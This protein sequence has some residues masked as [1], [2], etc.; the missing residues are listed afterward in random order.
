MPLAGPKQQRGSVG[1]PLL[2]STGAYPEAAGL[3]VPRCRRS[4]CHRWSA[5]ALHRTGH[6]Q[7]L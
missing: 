6:W 4:N 3:S 5:R 7:G 2:I 1:K